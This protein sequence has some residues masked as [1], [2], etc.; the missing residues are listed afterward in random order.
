MKETLLVAWCL[1]ADGQAPVALGPGNKGS[2]ACWSKYMG[3]MV[4]R[5][6]RSPTTLT[7]DGAPGVIRAI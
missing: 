1:D 2:E 7:T 6:L 5:G 4:N 3:H